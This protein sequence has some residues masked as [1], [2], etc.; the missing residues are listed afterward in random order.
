[1][2]KSHILKFYEHLKENQIPEDQP[3]EAQG[4]GSKRY[5][6]DMWT[7][8][9][10]ECLLGM[11]CKRMPYKTQKLGLLE[12]LEKVKDDA[13]VL[14]VGEVGRGLDIAVAN[15]IKE[16]KVICY[17]HNPIYKEYLDKY[18]K[19]VEFH[20]APT[21]VFLEKEW[22]DV[23]SKHIKEKTIFIMDNT[24]CRNFKQLEENE[25]IVHFIY[26]GKLLW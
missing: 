6:A 10:C 21:S 15:I 19:R 24:K 3:Q 5:T 26:Y 11:D 4:L 7:L 9:V 16:W 2:D 20:K 8:E 17:D 13:D 18:F 14:C 12:S 22:N 23:Y 25:N 1:M